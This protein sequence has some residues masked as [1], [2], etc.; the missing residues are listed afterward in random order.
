MENN[1]THQVSHGMLRSHL[2]VKSASLPA[3]ADLRGSKNCELTGSFAL[4]TVNRGKL[5]DCTH[6]M[7]TYR[8]HSVQLVETNTASATDVDVHAAHEAGC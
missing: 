2:T 1:E 7:R 3:L 5:E 6:K 4:E 8:V